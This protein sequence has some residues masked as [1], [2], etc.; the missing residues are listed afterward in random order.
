MKNGVLAILLIVGGLAVAGIN[1]YLDYLK[2]IEKDA[3]V[4]VAKLQAKS[5]C[6]QRVQ[7]QQQT[8][9]DEFNARLRKLVADVSYAVKRSMPPYKRSSDWQ[10]FAFDQLNLYEKSL[11][12]LHPN[13]TIDEAECP[14]CLLPKELCG[15]TF[16]G[17]L[18]G[19]AISIICRSK[20]AKSGSITVMQIQKRTVQRDIIN[21]SR[22]GDTKRIAVS[23]FFPKRLVFI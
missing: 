16:S 14:T 2:Q 10:E 17:P 12:E 19:Q 18:K 8:Q 11:V 13:G 22:K 23:G 4:E 5:E 1:V 9:L 6:D 7:T 15:Q 3:A 20:E 21:R